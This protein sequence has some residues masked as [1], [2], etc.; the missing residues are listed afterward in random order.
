MKH[1]FVVVTSRRSRFHATLLYFIVSRQQL[2]RSFGAHRGKKRGN[3]T[4][5]S[6][7]L[8]SLFFL[9][10]TLS[11]SWNRR[12][13]KDKELYCFPF[14]FRAFYSTASRAVPFY[15]ISIPL[16]LLLEASKC[17]KLDRIFFLRSRTF[18][19]PIIQSMMAGSKTAFDVCAT[20]EIFSAPHFSFP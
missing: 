12:K 6:L 18:F 13:G 8:F 9:S 14:F 16:S 17:S 20:L 1:E 19:S 7:S 5:G 3:K 15:R 11:L 2:N 4:E 10:L